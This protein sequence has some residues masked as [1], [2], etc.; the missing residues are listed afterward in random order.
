M[1]SKLPAG[2]AKTHQIHISATPEDARRYAKAAEREGI[3]L[4]EFARLALDDRAKSK[5]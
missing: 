4:A 2:K 3:S 1:P 5:R